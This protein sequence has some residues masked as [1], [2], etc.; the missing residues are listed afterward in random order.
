MIAEAYHAGLS[1]GARKRI[2]SNF[3]NGKL[4]IVVATVAF[5]MGLNKSD[6]RAVIHYNMPKGFESFVQEIGRAGRDGNAA[7]C[8]IFIE[9]NVRNCTC[10]LNCLMCGMN[11]ITV[12]FIMF[13]FILCIMGIQQVHVFAYIYLYIQHCHL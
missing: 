3:M 7:Y 10:V 2:Q 1:M 9:K 4:R 13:M 5:G 6:V 11:C 12:S 8:H